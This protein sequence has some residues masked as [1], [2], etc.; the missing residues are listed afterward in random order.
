MR[1]TVIT[2]LFAITASSASAYFDGS[3]W[4]W[5][6]TDGSN[7][8]LWG[9]GGEMDAAM[10]LASAFAGNNPSDYPRATYTT[11]QFGQ[12]LASFPATSSFTQDANT[13]TFFDRNDITVEGCVN[14]HR[15]VHWWVKSCTNSPADCLNAISANPTTNFP[16]GFA[17]FMDITFRTSCSNSASPDA[18]RVYAR[19]VFPNGQVD[20]SRCY[21]TEPDM[22][23]YG[24]APG[25]TQ[26]PSSQCLQF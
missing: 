13:P 12:G 3:L 9:L 26:V 20:T 18:T 22:I 7:P 5:R 21:V 14:N 1:T 17:N 16:A 4:R 6:L 19:P 8:S 25:F 23:P 2:I 24:A 15:R 11:R 10:K